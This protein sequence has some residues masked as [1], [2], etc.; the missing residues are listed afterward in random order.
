MLVLVAVRALRGD[1]P[2]AADELR[3]RV[4][5]GAGAPVVAVDGLDLATAENDGPG[6]GL[7]LL[8]EPGRR[9]ALLSP[10]RAARDDAAAEFLLPRRRVVVALL[11]LGEAGAS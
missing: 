1:T 9:S 8:A 4:A 6:L 2:R 10:G 3:R 11:E 5:H 7:T